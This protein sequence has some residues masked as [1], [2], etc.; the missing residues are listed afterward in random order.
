MIS[1][2]MLV[3][4]NMGARAEP[5]ST[6]RP[7]DAESLEDLTGAVVHD[8][9]NLLEIIVG[10][11]EQLRHSELTATQ[12]A[13]VNHIA[14]AAAR[15]TNLASQLVA[16][17]GRPDNDSDVLDLG[18]AILEMRGL[19]QRIVG[20]AVSVDCR[21]ADAPQ[22]VQLSETDLSQIML[23]LATNARDA[24]PHG[25]VLTIS[26]AVV[27]GG[28][29]DVPPPS[30]RAS[31]SERSELRSGA[32]VEDAPVPESL[33][34]GRREPFHGRYI[35]LDVADDGTGMTPDVRARAFDRYFTTKSTSGGTGLGLAIVQR[36]VRQRGGTIE[37]NTSNGRG[38]AFTILLPVSSQAVLPKRAVDEPLMS[39]GHGETV[40]VAD[41]EPVVCEIVSSLLRRLGYDVIEATSA[42]EA[43]AVAASGRRVDLLVT[44]LTLAD[45]SGT[46]LAQQFGAVSAHTRILY[47]SG[48]T[49]HPD[50]APIK[51]D[52]SVGFLQKPFDGRALGMQVRALLD[53]ARTER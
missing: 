31:A 38:T 37:V 19:L 32:P 26:T 11:C 51:G 35:R 13:E 30:G 46:T 10:C 34:R 20:D 45:I 9:N 23:N 18:H 4:D 7:P 36:L 44:D 5:R 43:L 3:P 2:Y 6:K 12:R 1:R 50:V 33:A 16:A 53:G 42:A 40:L 28:I 29:S 14:V 24:M 48:D 39:T 25:G 17:G 15:A 52:A 22:P 41:D 49:T 21:L 27:E 47:I 8:F